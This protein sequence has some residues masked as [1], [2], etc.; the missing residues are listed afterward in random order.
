[1]RKGLFDFL[2]DGGHFG[3]GQLFLIKAVKRLHRQ[4]RALGAQAL[5]PFVLSQ[6]SDGKASA[7]GIDAIGHEGH[8]VAVSRQG[9]AAGIF[10]DFHLQQAHGRLKALASCYAGGQ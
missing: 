5:Q 2:I 7:L 4:G 6:R 1:M 8:V 3:F 10:G 9:N